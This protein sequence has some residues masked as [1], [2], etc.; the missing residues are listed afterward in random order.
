LRAVAVGGVMVFHYGLLPFAF[1]KLGVSLFFVLSGFLITLLMVRE[2]EATGSVSLKRFYIRRALRIFPAYYVFLAVSFAW[3]AFQGQAV[4][5]ALVLVS[6]FYA[7]NYA[8]A[9]GAFRSTPVSHG[10]SLGVEEQFYLVWPAMLRA[11]WRRNVSVPKLILAGIILV[12]A[13]RTTLSLAGVRS[14]YVYYAFDTRFDCLLMGCGLAICV[15]DDWVQ[16]TARVVSANALLPIATLMLLGAI[17]VVPVEL[18]YLTVADSFEA[19]LL[20]ILLVQGLMLSA[21][22]LWSWLN[23]PVVRYLGT[24]SYPLYLYHQLA[25]NI[26]F[27]AVQSRWVVQIAS[28]VAMA[29]ALAMVSYHFIERPFLRRKERLS[30]MAAGEKTVPTAA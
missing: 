2:R 29:V 18:W 20:A 1:A 11:A 6:V 15:R 16:R 28:A 4:P 10:W 22:P 23:W 9:F 27:E 24:I 5:A 25:G 21:H 30:A 13:W 12:C 8:Q 17:H 3:M 7:L 14:G 19:I 26:A